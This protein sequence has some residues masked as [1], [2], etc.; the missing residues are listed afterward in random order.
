MLIL[1]AHGSRDP[2]WRASVE[3]VTRAVQ[4]DVGA[5]K[6]RLAYMDLTPPTLADIVAEA[7]G[8]GVR[9]VRVLPLF[10]ANEGHVDRDIRP[11]VDELRV[12]HRSVEVELLPAVGQHRLFCELLGKI[13]MEE[14]RSGKG[15]A[16]R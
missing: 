2:K 13:A 4:D 8:S 16:P 9:R 14:V 1:V 7:I 5:D 15:T 6:V 3:R 11:A 12:I 10:I